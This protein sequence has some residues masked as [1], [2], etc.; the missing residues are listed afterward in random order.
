MNTNVYKDIQSWK[1]PLHLTRAKLAKLYLHLFSAVQII[2]ITGSVGKTLTQNAIYKVLSQKYKCVVGEENLDP[3]FRIP[4][5]ILKVKPWDKFLILEYGVERPG[6]MDYYLSIIKPQQAVVTNISMTHLKYFR[7]V[8]GVFHEKSKLTKSLPASGYAL[9]NADDPESAKLLTH[10][11]AKVIW[12]G[13]KANKGVKISHYKQNLKGSRFRLHY[14]GQT[15]S[16][17]WKIIGQHQLQAAYAAATVGIINGVTLK[18]AAVGLSK[19]AAPTH[20]MNQIVTKR[21]N[22]IDDTY[23]SSPQAVSAA[24]ATVR[25]LGKGF[26]KIAVLGEMKDLGS[27]SNKIHEEI[28]KWVAKNNIN[29]LITVGSAAKAIALGANEVSF[30]GK[31]IN[32]TNTKEAI[33]EAKKFADKKSIIL[34]KGSRHAHLE[35]IVYGL[36]H[37]STE[38]VCYHCGK[39]K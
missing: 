26:K 37:K 39:L 31:V 9:L 35:R 25:E 20:R 34:I 3:T 16:V 21:I 14:K 24:L 7:D 38:I 27:I 4:Q 30:R 29:V 2:G 17:L 28:G 15:A 19:V 11:K 36:M 6:D 10:T 23:N 33:K 32:T 12:F 1:K 22:I 18:Q 5:T 13:K 8:S